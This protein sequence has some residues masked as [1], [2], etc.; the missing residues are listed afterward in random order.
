MT[1]PIQSAALP[2]YELSFTTKAGANDKNWYF[3][4]AGLSNFTASGLSVR[5]P[6]AKL[7]P[8]GR[9]GSLTFTN[10]L[11]TEAVNPT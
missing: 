5:V 2:R 4:F 3:F 6:V 9:Q 11:L 10:G 8:S 1:Q 7:T